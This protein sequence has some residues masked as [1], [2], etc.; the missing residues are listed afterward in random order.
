MWEL[1]NKKGWALMNWGLQTVVLAKT[2]E[3]PLDSKEI[4]PVNPK[5]ISPEYSSEGQF[6]GHQMWRTDSLENTLM[7]RKIEVGRRRGWQRMWWLDSITD[8]MDM[9]LS[10]LWELVMDREAWHAAVHGE[11]KSRSQLSDWTELNFSAKWCLC[12]STCS[13]S[14]SWLSFQGASIF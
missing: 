4:K 2:P 7:L 6:F 12:F 1:D 9:S 5:K 14:F 8:L 3:S 13:L 11:A 10:R